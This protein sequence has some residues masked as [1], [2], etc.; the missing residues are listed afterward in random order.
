M[1]APNRRIEQEDARH[2]CFS[3]RLLVF[4]SKAT[5]LAF[6]TGAQV[7]TLFFS[8]GGN[9]FS[10]GHL[11][12]ERFHPGEGVG[13]DAREEGSVGEVKKLE[14]LHQE[15]DE[16]RIKLV[17]VKKRTERKELVVWVDLNV[18][19]MG[20]EDMSAFFAA[21]M[22]RNLHPN[23][24][25]ASEINR[26]KHMVMEVPLAEVVTDGMDMQEM[27]PP[28]GFAAGMDME[29]MQMAIPQPPGLDDEMGMQMAI[30]QLLMAI[31]PSPEIPVGLETNAG[32]P[33]P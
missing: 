19:D 21:L 32:F 10:F 16:L 28:P 5:S 26:Q 18:H 2:V 8:P 9:V 7:A 11:I 4:F 15:F 25:F 27:P 22:C 23:Q 17:E 24:G 31:P 3:K 6:L 33:F 1:A 29:E 13:A 14:Q 30:P 12:V 20:D